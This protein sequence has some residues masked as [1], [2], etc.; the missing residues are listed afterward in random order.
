M[1]ITDRINRTGTRMYGSASVKLAATKRVTISE[2]LR[3]G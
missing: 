2:V 3:V 1:K